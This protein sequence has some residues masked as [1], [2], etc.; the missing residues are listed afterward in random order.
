MT[1]ER[2]VAVLGYSHRRNGRLHAICAD[3]LAH[4]QRL[5]EGARAVVL[6]GWSEA[7]PMRAAWTGP[8]VLLVCDREARSTAHNAANVAAAARKLGARELVVVTSAWH[9]AR[10]GILVGAALRG[11]GI[12]FSIETAEG[13][14][15]SWLLARELVCLALLPLQLRRARRMWSR[16]GAHPAEPGRAALSGPPFE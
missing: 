14:R 10:T 15:P 3:R 2:V 7:E 6:S 1:T 16:E 5:A 4:A 11:S 12:R 9:R 13:P 8:D